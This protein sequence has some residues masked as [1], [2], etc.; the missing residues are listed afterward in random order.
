MDSP[1]LRPMTDFQLFFSEGFQ[2][3]TDLNGFDHIIFIAALT[4]TYLHSDWKKLLV[5]ITAFTIGHSVT[6]ALSSLNM[7]SF[8]RDVIEFLIPVTIFLTGA[9]NLYLVNDPYKK[10]NNSR[11]R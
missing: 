6:L 4:S 7:V 8:K 10:K 9:Y 5:L 1:Y 2:H 11:R 3:S